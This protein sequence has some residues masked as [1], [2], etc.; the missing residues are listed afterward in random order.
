MGGGFGVWL[1]FVLTGYLL[2]WPFAK[3]GFGG[4]RVDLRAYARNRALR[5]LPLYLAVLLVLFPLQEHGGSPGQWLRF[6]PSA[7]TS[8]SPRWA[9]GRRALVA[10][11]RASLL[12]RAAAAGGGCAVPVAALAS[13]GRGACAPRSAWPAWPCGCASTARSGRN[14]LPP[15]FFFASGC[16]GAAP[17]P[18]SR[19]AVAAARRYERSLGWPARSCSGT[20]VLRHHYPWHLLCALAG[21]AAARRLR[22]AAAAGDRGACARSGGRWRAVGVAS[23]SLYVWLL[24][25]RQPP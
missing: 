12:R 5:I 25:D 2:F 15:R 19:A 10:R 14:S 9:R 7:R 21:D 22:A 23:Y 13:P 17:R 4:G 11:D 16:C 8:R 3:E 24:S 1:F 6:L 18:P 20:I